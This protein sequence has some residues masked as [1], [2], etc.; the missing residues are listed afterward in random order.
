[1]IGFV[2]PVDLNIKVLS[3]N[4]LNT[5]VVPPKNSAAEFYEVAL[6][7]SNRR[8]YYR[9]YFGRPPYSVVYKDLKPGQTYRFAYRLGN[10]RAFQDILSESRTKQFT[11]PAVGKHG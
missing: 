9:V 10:T 3:A 4:S 11:M 8:Y 6:E 2:A 1:M 5:T 7:N